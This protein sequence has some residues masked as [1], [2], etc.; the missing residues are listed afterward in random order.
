MGLRGRWHRAGQVI[1]DETDERTELASLRLLRPVLGAVTG[2]F[3]AAVVALTV[4]PLSDRQRAEGWWLAVAAVIFAG[5][6][7]LQVSAR[8]QRAFSPELEAAA[9]FRGAA[10]LPVGA[11]VAG[12][13]AF[14]LY[15]DVA[16]ATTVAVAI[17]IGTAAGL[18]GRYWWLSRRP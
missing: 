14:G 15:H 13:L 3:L 11:A 10:W 6:I 12:V 8:R 9:I 18:A 5:L 17:L 16:R 1:G 2:V 4:L 7:T